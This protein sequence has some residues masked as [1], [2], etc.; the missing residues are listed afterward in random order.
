M[1][2][3]EAEA[4]LLGVIGGRDAEPQPAAREHR[5]LR[6]ERA[7]R[8]AGPTRPGLCGTHARLRPQHV[9]AD[10]RDV[11]GAGRALCGASRGSLT[12]RLRNP[13][14]PAARRLSRLRAPRA[15]LTSSLSLG[16]CLTGRGHPEV[17]GG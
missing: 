11:R 4:A 13:R 9:S 7:P 5:L 17:G 10:R 16:G 6:E 3:G 8:A 2:S 14:R 1:G 15:P 12:G